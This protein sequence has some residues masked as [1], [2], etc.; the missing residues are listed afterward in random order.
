MHD[1]QEFKGKTGQ[2]ELEKENI[3]AFGLLSNGIEDLLQINGLKTW[4]SQV[5]S[6]KFPGL[7]ILSSL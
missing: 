7:C 4:S 2:L 5:L 1:T 6:K 3:L